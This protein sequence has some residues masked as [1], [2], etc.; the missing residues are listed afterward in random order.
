MPQACFRRWRRRPDDKGSRL[1]EQGKELKKERQAEMRE[2]SR[3]FV[4]GDRVL[5]DAVFYKGELIDYV[6]KKSLGRTGQGREC[7]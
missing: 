1:M 2:R 4:Q 5:V 7:Q 3:E 6:E